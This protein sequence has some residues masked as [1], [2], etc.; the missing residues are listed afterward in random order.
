M[1]RG[2]ESLPGHVN[3]YPYKEKRQIKALIN[4][5]TLLIQRDPEQ[6]V[7]DMAL[8][9]LDAVLE[10]ARKLLPHDPVVQATS[11]V[12]TPERIISGDVVRAAD[13]LVVAMQLE[14]ALGPAPLIVA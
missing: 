2:F 3:D 4:S 7:Q 6:E 13:A 1:G 9:V 10:A 14:A 11:G 12:I 5:L 8:P